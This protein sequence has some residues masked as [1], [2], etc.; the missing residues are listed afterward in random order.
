M[1]P[2]FEYLRQFKKVSDEAE[3]LVMKVIKKRYPE[4]SLNELVNIFEQ[5]ITGD[6]GK[7]YSADPETLLD[8]VRT[9]TKRQY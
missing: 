1:N 7:V 5:G 3:E 6:F 2:A 9:Y 4:I 8:W